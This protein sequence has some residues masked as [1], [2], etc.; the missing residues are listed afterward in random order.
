[1]LD[2]LGS[3]AVDSR[4]HGS[5]LRSVLTMFASEGIPGADPRERLQAIENR[6]RI[7][8]VG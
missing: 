6:S 1:M 3:R 4:R 2:G 8:G 7:V 5:Y